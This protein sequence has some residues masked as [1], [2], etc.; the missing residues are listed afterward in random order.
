MMIILTTKSL[1]NWGFQI[2]LC[3]FIITY[4]GVTNDDPAGSG[5]RRLARVWPLIIWYSSLVLLL[6]ITYQFAALPIIR[7]ALELDRFL[8]LLPPWIRKNLGIIGFSVYST[9]IWEKFLVYLVYFAVGVYV[10]KQTAEWDRFETE[11]AKE[12]LV[13]PLKGDVSVNS[14]M[15]QNYFEER[16][17]L[18]WQ[19]EY[20]KIRFSTPYLAYKIKRGWVLLDKLS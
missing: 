2:I 18:N 7:Q 16:P 12:V 15:Q 14:D 11:K 6:Q 3:I 8:D 20:A 4:I 13:T 17:N 5:P 1:V 19:E 9:F 10:R